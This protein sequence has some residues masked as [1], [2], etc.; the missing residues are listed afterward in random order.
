MKGIKHNLIGYIDYTCR[1]STVGD[2]KNRAV[3]LIDTMLKEGKVPILVGGTNY[4]IHS[5]LYDALIDEEPDMTGTTSQ[6]VLTDEEGF[7]F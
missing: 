4:Y 3:E 7:F 5:V 1:T 2:Y 6:P